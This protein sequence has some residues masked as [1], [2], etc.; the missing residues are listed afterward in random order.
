MEPV[1]LAEALG[2]RAPEAGRGREDERTAISA[3][4][5]LERVPFD[6]RALVDVAGEDELGAGR[7]ERP[8][9][10]VPV[11]EREL[12]RGAP[13][14]PARWWWQTTMFSA[15]GGAVEQRQATDARRA[16]SSRPP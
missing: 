5:G 12:A 16:A 7:G 9:R 11:L 3:G 14:C 4:R 8:Q 10:R 13:R 2:A 15:P 1:G 6:G